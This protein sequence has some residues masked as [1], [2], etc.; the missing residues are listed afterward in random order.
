MKDPFGIDVDACRG[1]QARLL[2]EMARQG[3]ELTIVAQAEHVQW[4]TGPRFAWVFQPFAALDASGR[5]TLVAPERQVPDEVAADVV[6]TYPAKWH[7]TLRNDQREAASQA[8]RQALGNSSHRRIGV[9][10]SSF[11]QHLADLCDEWADIEPTMYRLRRRKDGDELAR[12]R[13]AIAGTARMYERAR[14]LIVPG[15]SELEVFSELQ[16]SAVAEFGEMMTGTGNDYQCASRGGPPRPRPA[17]AG[18][19]YIL[20]LGPAFR[21]YFADNARTIAVT[22]P[23][24]DQLRA[25]ESVTQVLSMVESEVRPGRS[26][27]EL[28]EKAQA[29]LAECP[30]GVFN[31]HLGHGIGLFPHEAPHLNPNWNDSFEE[32]DVF[33]AEPGLYG[34]ELKA[35]IRI[36]NDYLVT[37]DG[38]EL[39]THFSWNL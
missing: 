10:F 4:L 30:V 11:P 33:T 13:K 12:L 8:L 31:H 29:M 3:L 18:E 16:A 20:D 15:V 14:E 6:C 22:S 23:T 27:R 38:V 24:D 25:W 17:Q 28:F 1:R 26:A 19:L 9:E 2:D 5:L 35:G 37:V 39:L 7:S 32:G 36:E 34:P 21:G